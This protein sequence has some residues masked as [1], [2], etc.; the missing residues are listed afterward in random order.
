MK[1]I[2]AEGEGVELIVLHSEKLQ[3]S[4]DE[5]IFRD[6]GDVIIGEVHLGNRNAFPPVLSLQG[7]VFQFEEFGRDLS[8]FLSNEVEGARLKSPLYDVAE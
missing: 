4:E 7:Q 1:F 6:D 5:D 2:E 3:V 8:G